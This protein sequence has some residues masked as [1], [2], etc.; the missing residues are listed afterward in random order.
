[1]GA[2]DDLLADVPRVANGAF[3][4]L[5]QDADAA[6]GLDPNSI[7]MNM[8]FGQ[9]FDLP[10][11]EALRPVGAAAVWADNNVM[12]PLARGISSVP[13]LVADV[14]EWSKDK[15]T[16]QTSNFGEVTQALQSDL[17]IAPRP[18]DAGFGTDVMEAIGGGMAGGA[19]MSSGGLMPT[20]A[21]EVPSAVASVL[22][23]YAGGDIGEY[24]GGDTGRV[25]GEVIGSLG[26]GTL[27]NAV[28]ASGRSGT[29]G[30]LAKPNGQS[31]QAY[32]TLTQAGITPRP[33]LVG[34]KQASRLE[35]SAAN[36]PVVGGIVQ[37]R[38]T[39]G[40]QQ[41]QDALYGASDQVGPRYR[42]GVQEA[43]P[44]DMLGGRMRWAANEG[45][46]NLD[47]YFQQGYS[48]FYNTVPEET[49]VVPDNLNTAANRQ[50]DVFTGESQATQGAVNGYVNQEI[51]PALRGRQ[52]PNPPMQGP[53][54]SGAPLNTS[55]PPDP[56]GV[57]IQVARKAGTE[58]FY[59]AQGGKMAGGAVEQVRQ[60]W[61]ADIENALLNDPNMV[62]AFPDFNARAAQVER[63]RVLNTE[64]ALAGAKDISRSG[65]TPTPI[66][67]RYYVGGDKPALD[68]V[69]NSVSDQSAYNMGSEP[70][71]MAVLQ[72][73]APQ[74]YPSIAAE[75]IRNEA[76]GAQPYGD[77]NVSPQV[78]ATWWNS[79]SPNEKMIYT[80][81]R[82]H[83]TARS[84]DPTNPAVQAVE[85]A[86][87]PTMDRLDNL[88]QAGELFRQAGAQANPSGTAPTL[89]TMGVMTGLFT[90]PLKTIA[91][92][93]SGGALSRMGSSEEL[94]R[95]IAGRD[96]GWSGL[97]ADA[98]YRGL[99]HV[100]AQQ[101]A[102]SY[103][104]EDDN[105]NRYDVNGNLVQ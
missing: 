68:R 11:P 101:T 88:G 89:A 30:L 1:M 58:A 57:P 4:D 19:L 87:T 9:S 38:Q 45:R 47:R 43:M 84:I 59:D 102:P 41:F 79:L 29:R 26:G 74:H 34:N 15:L 99:G 67:G 85:N 90:H 73:T 63:L 62:A 35:N 25:V 66:N 56:Q 61:N 64:Y 10:V 103:F 24:V 49:L 14:A 70:G 81:E 2:F 80:N 75:V 76:Q 28:E 55:L 40:F 5:T 31:A 3:S 6:P 69:S 78:F 97:M 105:G 100:S 12:A 53:T 82:S 20:L 27:P 94:A 83:G 77:V 71:H 98:M 54:P 32:D 91:G 7:R 23:Q 39:Q 52:G 104:M 8:G 37:N 42:Q 21:R 18:Y 46:E 36:F 44:T 13:G 60:A 86:P 51:T 93:T 48:D 95:I 16:G 72:R 22:G 50:A 33:G 65:G 96:I 92:L 17:G